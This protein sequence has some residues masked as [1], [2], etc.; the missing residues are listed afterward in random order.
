[1]DKGIEQPDITRP[2]KRRK[3]RGQP[4]AKPRWASGAKTIV[5]TAV[6][7]E[8]RIWYTINNGTLAEIYF[9]DV[10]QANTRS[11]RFVVTGE[12]GFFSDEMWDA[13]HKVEWLDSGVP[14]CCIESVCKSGS[15]STYERDHP[16]SDARRI[17]S[18]RAL[19]S[20]EGAA[21]PAPLSGNRRTHRRSR[22]EQRSLGRR[23]QG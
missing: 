11:V 23:V 21:A 1:M 15:V 12:D 3:A 7:P 17:A 14:G 4:G 8:S 2:R 20:R 19:R 5:G 10:D 9:P 22:R 18:V 16:G 13:E 6:K